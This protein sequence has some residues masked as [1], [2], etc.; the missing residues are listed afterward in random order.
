[1]LPPIA[2]VTFYLFISEL[3]IAELSMYEKFSGWLLLLNVFH[4]QGA[5][6][7]YASL[8]LVVPEVGRPL[9]R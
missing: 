6:N 5:Q 4:H 8:P 1:M 2:V 7:H 3:W 9:Q